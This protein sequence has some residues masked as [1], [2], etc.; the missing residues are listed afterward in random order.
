M[1][2]DDV[3][4]PKAAV[5]K[6]VKQAIPPAVKYNAAEISQAV[7]SLTKGKSKAGFIK[8]LSAK[9]NQVCELEGKKTLTNAHFLEA[10]RQL[11]FTG[12]VEEVKRSV[13]A[14]EQTKQSKPKLAP[15]KSIEELEEEQKKLFEEAEQHFKPHKSAPT[16]VQD[17][18]NYDNE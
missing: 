4:L 11:Q 17:T 8:L 1:V 15:T 5:Q 13:E 10:L 14:F 9:A 7:G 2:K 3:S 6:L 16:V 18:E 12:C